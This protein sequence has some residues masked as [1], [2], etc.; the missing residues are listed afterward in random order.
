MRMKTYTPLLFP[1]VMLLAFCSIYLAPEPSGILP[2]SVSE[3]LPVGWRLLG[4]YGIKTQETEKERTVL[5]PDTKFSK[6]VYANVDEPIFAVSDMNENGA[7]RQPLPCMV[8]VVFSGNDMNNSIHRPER[9]LPAQGH[10]DLR[11]SEVRLRLK[12]GHVL[13][14]TRLSTLTKTVDGKTMHHIHYYVFVGDAVVTANHIWRTLYDVRDR[15]F[16]HK[17]Q[18]WAYVQLSVYYGDAVG[19]DEKTADAQLIRL[20]QDLL[21]EVIDWQRVQAPQEEEKTEMSSAVPNG[22]TETEQMP[23]NLFREVLEM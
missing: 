8:S 4:W 17:V 6:A 5:S 1:L 20:I 21:P 22:N 23:E 18:R 12:D 15:V 11:A 14:F 2:S 13:P 3:D 7:K 16:S 9:C 19:V 10:Y